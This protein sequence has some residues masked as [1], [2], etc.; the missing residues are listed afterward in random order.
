LLLERKQILNEESK[1]I[2][3]YIVE[4][5]SL[6]KLSKNLDYIFKSNE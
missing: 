5:M 3:N 1:K 4:N 2:H 6:D